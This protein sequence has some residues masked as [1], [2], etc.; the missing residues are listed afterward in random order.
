M[1]GFAAD[2]MCS[3]SRST[4][5]ADSPSLPALGSGEKRAKRR[6]RAFRL[7]RAK[8]RSNAEDEQ[9][10]A[11]S[12][13]NNT[14]LSIHCLLSGEPKHVRGDCRGTGPQDGKSEHPVR[15][16]GRETRKDAAAL[17]PGRG[18]ICRLVCTSVSGLSISVRV[19]VRP[20]S[21]LV[22]KWNWKPPQTVSSFSAVV[23]DR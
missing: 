19:R 21:D 23:T 10:Q 22:S 13:N 8:P 4:S 5:A 16:G 12:E 14:P 9:H 6:G 7:S 1:A 3:C 20:F 11:A 2:G 15:L 17:L 18:V